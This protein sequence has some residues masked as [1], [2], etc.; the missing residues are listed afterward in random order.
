[1]NKRVKFIFF[2]AFISFAILSR[3]AFPRIQD[4]SIEE[5]VGKSTMA[6]VKINVYDKTGE[7]CGFGTGFFIAPGKILTC[8]HVIESAHSLSINPFGHVDVITPYNISYGHPKILK[9][10]GVLDLALLEVDALNQP[11]LSLETGEKLIK[12]QPVVTVGNPEEYA[13]LASIGIVS[14][15]DA[16][17]PLTFYFSAPVGP[18][19]SGSP[20]LNMKGNL[21]GIVM[22]TKIELSFINIAI[23]TERISE[24]LSSPDN[25]KT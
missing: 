16:A 5:V 22:A 13:K 23:K 21:I 2:F 15:E 12:G 3:L 8:A 10:N 6:V 4:L 19:S 7:K 9:A 25:P 1:M 14:E 20:I 17:D 11:S 24:F 18:G